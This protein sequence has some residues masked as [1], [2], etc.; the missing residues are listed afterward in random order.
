MV[1]CTVN[2]ELTVLLT[3]NNLQMLIEEKGLEN[4]RIAIELNNEIVPRSEYLKR[5]VMDGDRVEI[6]HAV[7][8]G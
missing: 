3:A 1:K 6:V 5:P 2:G 7:G 8:G 4:K